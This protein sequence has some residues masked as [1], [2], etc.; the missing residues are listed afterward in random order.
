MERVEGP[1]QT[2]HGPGEGEQDEPADPGVVAQEFHP[3]LV[4][5]HED[6]GLPHGRVGEVPAEEDGGPD[7]EEREVVE[8]HPVGHVDQG[9]PEVEGRPLDAQSVV[10]ARELV[11]LR[12][13]GVEDRV[14]GE[15]EQ[16]E[17]RALV[18][19]EEKPRD[20]PDDRGE[21][22]GHKKR[23]PQ[24]ETLDVDQRDGDR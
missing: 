5:P 24:G 12:G 8:V 20:K 16:C 11:P 4:L 19:Q 1:C 14:E 9:P 23:T 10:T 6:N 13:D 2:C 15:G 3:L 22:Y 7:Q 17:V 18:P 21:G